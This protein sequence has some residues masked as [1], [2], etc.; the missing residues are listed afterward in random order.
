ML[1]FGLGTLFVARL[2]E[3]ALIVRDTFAT[4]AFVQTDRPAG[5]RI[6]EA[7]RDRRKAPAGRTA[8]FFISDGSG[9]EAA[10]IVSS[11]VIW[12]SRWKGRLISRK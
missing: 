10:G 4:H 5:R 7:S 3:A 8:V 2:A 6:K 11:V 12:Q 1:P 9:G